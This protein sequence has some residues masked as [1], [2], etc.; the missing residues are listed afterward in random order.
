MEEHAFV[1][2]ILEDDVNHHNEDTSDCLPLSF[3]LL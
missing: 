3:K 1:S 2:T